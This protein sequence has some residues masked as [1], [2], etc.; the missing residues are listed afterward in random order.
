M[1]TL[2]RE[3]P[4]ILAA[5]AFGGIPGLVWVYRV[6]A[7]GCARALEFPVDPAILEEA[8]NHGDWLWLHFAQTDARAAAF[9]RQMALPLRAKDSLLAHDEHLSLHLEGD[10]AFGVLADWQHALEDEFGASDVH[11]RPNEDREIGR[12]HFALT[13]GLVISTR[14]RALRSVHQLRCRLDEGVRMES[15]PHVLE[16]IIEQFTVSVAE[17]T[18]ELG[19]AL[20]GVEDRVLSDRSA[21]ERRDLGRLRRR[22]VRMHR[23]LKALR[24][25]IHQFEQRH[26]QRSTHAMIDVAARLLQRFDEL[27]SD[28]VVIQ[29]RAR[30]LQDEVA[31][32][33]TDQTNRQLYFLS[34]LTA[35]FLPP[36]L[37]VGVFGMN[38]KGLPL[39]DDP[40]GFAIAI[41]ICVASSAI[42]YDVLRRM[43][44]R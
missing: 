35:L 11:D 37:V 5:P 6:D 3:L 28:I 9:I 17:V 21:D 23:P 44:I 33:L 20:D 8:R 30:L 27:D 38:T 41:G 2:A 40:S 25:V 36:T 16:A 1:N 22:A 7:D 26:Q 13:D 34:I 19:D 24:R 39:T 18:R 4:G 29:D 42:V 10:T 15:A 14:R 43:G 32:K 31:A 12:L